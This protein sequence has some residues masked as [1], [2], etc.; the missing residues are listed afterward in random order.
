M[1]SLVSEK[2]LSILPTRR[3]TA[4]CR[5]CG[6]LSSP[7]AKDTLSREVVLDAIK[8]AA[9]LDFKLIAFTG[10]EATLE[11]ETLSCAVEFARDLHLRTRLVTNAHW[12]ESRKRAQEVIQTFRRWGLDELNVSTGDEHARFVPLEFVINSLVEGVLAGYDMQLMIEYRKDRVI[13][14]DR[15]LIHLTM[16]NLPSELFSKIEITESPWM[17]LSPNQFSSY[18]MGQTVSHDNVSLREGCKSILQ[19]YAIEPDGQVAAC[20]GLGVSL[21]PELSECDVS[22]PNFLKHALTQAENDF[23]KMWLR[24]EGPEKILA[25]ASQKDAS[26]LW[27]GQYAHNCQACQKIYRDPKVQAV[28]EHYYEEVLAN[29]ATSVVI[30]EKLLDTRLAKK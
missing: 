15:I 12:A 21:I 11:W 3:C 18:G 19:T 8:Q 17:P 13:T 10:G 20:C 30:D 7:K 22:I 29:V 4:A 6:S 14:K 2:V 24:Y 9:E 1:T 26:I 23:L 27:E 25:W 16:M 5:H 28:I